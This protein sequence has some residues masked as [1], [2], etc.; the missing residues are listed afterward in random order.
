MGV[1]ALPTS[2]HNIIRFDL[3]DL[4]IGPYDMYIYIN[5][6]I[7]LGVKITFNCKGHCE[8]NTM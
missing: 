6:K 7:I 1:S 2:L 5:F 8:D 3:K 4:Q